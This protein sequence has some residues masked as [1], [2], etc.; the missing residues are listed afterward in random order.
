VKVRVSVV[1]TSASP[2][3]PR[4]EIELLILENEVLIIPEVGK[5]PFHMRLKSTPGLKNQRNEKFVVGVSYLN[6]IKKKKKTKR[7]AMSQT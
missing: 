5:Q 6:S 4:G 7:N 2:K 1:P 3:V